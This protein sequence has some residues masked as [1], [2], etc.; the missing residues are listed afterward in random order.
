MPVGFTP[1]DQQPI[2]A[3]PPDQTL[4]I[5]YQLPGEIVSDGHLS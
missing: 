5:C 4:I 2:F 1:M 3:T